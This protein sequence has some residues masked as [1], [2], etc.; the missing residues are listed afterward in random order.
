MKA[1]ILKH[2]SFIWNLATLDEPLTDLV[3]LEKQIRRNQ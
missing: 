3:K 2:F 1:W